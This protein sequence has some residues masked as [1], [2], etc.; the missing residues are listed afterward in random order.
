[1]FREVPLRALLLQRPALSTC[2]PPVFVGLI[3]SE[4]AS[5]RDR[6]RPALADP[7]I[8]EA[9]PAA[10]HQLREDAHLDN[11]VA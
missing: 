6:V 5:S 3:V 4:V 11:R 2:R 9:E 7:Q 10:D 1:M 8:L